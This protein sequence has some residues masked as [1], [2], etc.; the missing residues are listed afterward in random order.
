MISLIIV[1]LTDSVF[2]TYSK[3]MLSS[4]LETK[5][6]LIADNIAISIKHSKAGEKYVENLI[7]QNLR[8]ASLALQ[9]KLD[10]DIEK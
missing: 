10:P 5:L 1:L 4:E 3:R 9:Y 7:G 2:Y 8:T 6:E